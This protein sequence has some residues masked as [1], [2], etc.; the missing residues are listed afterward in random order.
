MSAII[1][2]LEKKPCQILHKKHVWG[3]LIAI[4]VKIENDQ[5]SLFQSH[6]GEIDENWQCGNALMATATVFKSIC[7]YGKMMHNRISGV[8]MAL[9]H[10]LNFMGHLNITWCGVPFLM[11][12]STFW[13][14]NRPFLYESHLIFRP[15]TAP[16][17]T[18]QQC[19]KPKAYWCRKTTIKLWGF[20][21]ICH[22]IYLLLS[23]KSWNP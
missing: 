11:K 19:T 17:I 2:I 23:F 15:L 9:Y 5:F 18:I 6:E 10:D 20:Q 3:N 16:A 13:W 4:I 14:E 7:Y 8:T 1:G 21:L 12:F 22:L